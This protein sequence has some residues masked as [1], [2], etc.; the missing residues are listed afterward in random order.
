[1]FFSKKNVAS[2]TQSLIENSELEALR[3]KAE[4]FDQL[5]ALQPQ[6]KANQIIN[7]SRGVNQGAVQGLQD[8]E[9]SYQLLQQ[10]VE[11]SREIEALS[12]ESAN[13]ANQTMSTSGQTID[14]L[15]ELAEKIESA[16]QNI[17][18]CTGLLSSL[19]EN[20]QNINQLVD[21]IK[22]IADQ[23]N[24]L[25]LNAAIEAARAGEHGRGFAVVADEVRALANT[26]NK[27][28]EQIQ[29]E[30]AKIMDISETIIQKQLGVTARISDSREIAQGTVES[31]D[32]L[33]TI[34]KENARA[35]QSVIDQLEVQLQGSNQIVET[36]GVLVETTRQAVATSSNNVQLGEN[37]AGDLDLLS[38]RV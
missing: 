23:T 29:G 4:L 15:N 20:N 2:A 26:A 5:A 33:T 28:A 1:M 3:R 31:L 8:L 34:S 27:S 25:A 30:M 10:F 19:N 18:E 9:G 32:G 13:S 17:A 35:A 16:E 6:Q 14:Q 24:L 36:M 21:S 7:N 22:G 38:Q 37:L 11:Q 12:S